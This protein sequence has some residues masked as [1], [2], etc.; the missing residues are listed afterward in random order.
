M[1]MS[2]R[3]R[4]D[5]DAFIDRDKPL[6]FKFDGR[7]YHGFAGDTLASALLANG[8]HLVARSFKYHR[9]RGIMTAGPEEPNAIVEVGVG[10]RIEPNCRATVVELYDGL[11]ARPQNC[12]PSLNFD[13][14]AV[15]NTIARFIPAGFY[16]KTF[17]RPAAWWEPLYERLLRRAAGLGLVPPEPDPAR[18][19]QKYAHFDVVIV[20]AGP[21]G[22]AAARVAAES[23]VR[24]LV[25]DDQSLPG[26]SLKWDDSRIDGQPSKQWIEATAAALA[27]LPNVALL[28][29]TTAFGL[30][31][32]GMLA[33][34][35]RVN[36]HIENPSERQ[37]RQRL[38]FVRARKVILAC[39]SI[40]RPLVFGG[41]DRP[42]I[43]LA[44][45][46]RA[47]VNQYAVRPGR[48]ALIFTNND[49]AY[50]TAIDLQ[51]AGI[52]VKAVVDVRTSAGPLTAVAERHGIPVLHEHFIAA[53]RGRKRV[54]GAQIVNRSGAIRRW[55]D[56][57]LICS[58]GGWNPTVH[59]HSQAGGTTR[60]SEAT[61]A[62]IPEPAS[63]AM[64]SIGAMA[65]TFGLAGCL[66]DG[67]AAAQ[68]IVLA[69]G[70]HAPQEDA[71]H[72]LE[73]RQ[74]ATLP[75]W[76]MPSGI[77]SS[78]PRFVDFQ[79]DVT[80]KDIEL[81][82]RESFAAPEHL[83]RYTTLGM[84]TDQG[85]TSN[86]VG[87]GMMASYRNVAM[88]S[89]GPTT[90][91]PPYTPTPLGLF[92]GR[93]IGLNHRPRR[94]GPLHEWHR[95]N[96]AEFEEVQSWLRPSRYRE[97][98]E[99]A[100]KAIEREVR[101]MRTHAGILDLS[102]LGKIEVR[103]PDAATFLDRMYVDDIRSMPINGV[104]AATMLREDSFVLEQ[105]EV[106]R[107]APDRFLLLTANEGALLKHLE[108]HAK[109]LWPNWRLLIVPVT[110]QFAYFDVVGPD[111]TGAIAAFDHSGSA[112]DESVNTAIFNDSSVFLTQH[113]MF[114]ESAIRV[115]VASDR[116]REV[117][118]ALLSSLARP[119]VCGSAALTVMRVE[120]GELG[121][122]EITGRVTLTDVGLG[123]LGKYKEDFVGRSLAQ[124][125]ALSSTDREVV[126]RVAP[127]ACEM[128]IREGAHIETIHDPGASVGVITS[129]TWSPTLNRTVALGLLHAR[130][131][132]E[133]G[134]WFA[135]SPLHGERI[136]VSI[137]PRLT[138]YDARELLHQ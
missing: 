73:V 113:A 6:H 125:E 95:D 118:D 34:A 66:R 72:A 135:V 78:Q 57:D 24:L 35:E 98:G 112:K 85:K 63:D 104:I 14:R 137:Q 76:N 37:P 110:E 47:Y 38:W 7:S 64:I 29:R 71:P 116:A 41:N 127:V 68:R 2:P 26:G 129:S 54:C 28:Q 109:V 46:A 4:I 107:L 17:M 55:I 133:G 60:W 89:T 33:L 74:E 102:F 131:M 11:V 126:V 108:Y 1:T 77:R 97:P 99:S 136:E 93:D 42:G 90:F 122:N 43:M 49:S 20:G 100:S 51:S 13:L 48:H 36:D 18:Y 30:Y 69:L 119:V 94:Q 19:E 23:G 8:V 12:W 80:S 124:R 82:H 96:G 22:L 81:A 70:K 87:L 59:L 10:G 40:E 120:A 62:F 53:T 79:N 128:P 3:M 138:S 56:C 45:A 21:A 88:T 84:G 106:E 27:R 16:Y 117:W 111:R 86:V 121:S 83:K 75:M 130:A 115:R 44:S 52:D 65:G 61:S 105:N 9:P 103:G 67:T 123:G 92:A 91:R 25:V 31:D 132:T 134:R 39:G 58:S 114:G 15:H 50:A 32:H 101:A 5:R